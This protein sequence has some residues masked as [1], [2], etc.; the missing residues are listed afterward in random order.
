[1][2]C[3]ILPT[4]E[5]AGNRTIYYNCDPA[6]Y[7]VG[8]L[9][10]CN[11][12]CWCVT[13]AN[14][15]PLPSATCFAGSATLVPFGLLYLRAQLPACLGSP[16]LTLDLLYQLS[17][18]CQ[19]QQQVVQEQ[20]YQQHLRDYTIPDDLQQGPSDQLQQPQQLGSAATA[21]AAVALWQQ[22]LHAIYSSLIIHYWQ[23]GSVI[24]AFKLLDQQ[25]QE[26]PQSIELWSLAGR[27]QLQLNM[28]QHA[29]ASFTRVQQLFLQQQQQGKALPAAGGAT[30]QPTQHLSA[31]QRMVHHNWGCYHA[32]NHNMTLAQHEFSIAQHIRNPSSSTAAAAS[33]DPLAASDL[34]TTGAHHGYEAAAVDGIAAANSAVCL[35]HMG[36]LT[37]AISALEAGLQQNPQA[38]LQECTLYNLGMMYDLAYP[39][40]IAKQTRH[41]LA[42]SVLRLAADDFDLSCIELKT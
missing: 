37:E 20:Q 23:Q 17:D 8:C 35:L 36:E 10:A 14:H 32:L 3:V 41:Q 26:H 28:L 29:H 11:C 2:L 24:T 13:P 25:L 40:A 22:R 33:D 38:F 7:C 34:E 4:L 12:G 18:Y 21:T 30:A 16:H 15:E 5:K 42:S 6:Q 1:M 31:L 27:L 39:P 19:Q 9:S